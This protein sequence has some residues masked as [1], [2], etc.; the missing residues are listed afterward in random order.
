MASKKSRIISKEKKRSKKKLKITSKLKIAKPKGLKQIDEDTVEI[1][2]SARTRN[3]PKELSGQFRKSFYELSKDEDSKR[4]YSASIDFQ[5]NYSNRIHDIDIARGSTTEE[6]GRAN[7]RQRVDQNDEIVIHNHPFHTEIDSKWERVSGGDI[8]NLIYLKDNDYK[9]KAG[10]VTSANGQFIRY[11][12]VDL[13]KARRAE[14]KAK[15]EYNNLSFLEKEKYGSHVDWRIETQ[16]EYFAQNELVASMIKEVVSPETERELKK[17]DKQYD[18]DMKSIEDDSKLSYVQETRKINKLNKKFAKDYEKMKSEGKVKPNPKYLDLKKYSARQ[19]ELIHRRRVFNKW[20]KW[21]RE[22]WGV[23][24]KRM[25]KNFTTPIRAEKDLDL[26]QVKRLKVLNKEI[27]II[28]DVMVKSST[29]GKR[30]DE[31]GKERNKLLDERVALLKDMDLT[32]EDTE[33]YK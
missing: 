28:T 31:L 30:F 32:I 11:R 16:Y 12:V 6:T 8:H 24:V 23:E 4:E 22:E 15:Q 7:V 21:L 5:P 3:M 33:I 17:L 10:F 26:K 14:Y 19:R 13:D 27:D 9:V 25:P 18:N 2:F 1:E 20:I 29:T